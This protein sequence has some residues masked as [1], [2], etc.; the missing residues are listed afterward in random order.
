MKTIPSQTE[1][2][3]ETFEESHLSIKSRHTQEFNL[4]KIIAELRTYRDRV[5]S[6]WAII[7]VR[8]S[9]D[10]DPLPPLTKY[11]DLFTRRGRG[12]LNM[13]DFFYEMSH[14]KIDI[15]G[16][17][18][19]GWYT[20]DQRRADYVGNVYPQPVG[21]INR[22]GLLDAARAKAIAAGVNLADYSGVV[23]S[24]LNAVDLC[25]WVGGMA[26][27][28][29]SFSLSPSLMG[30]EM[31]HGYGLD[32]ARLNGSTEDYRD[33]WDV[34]STA[35]YPW[36]EADHSEFTKV[37]PGLN[38][39]SMR[40]LGWLDETRVWS[41]T[42]NAFDTTIQLRPLHSHELSGHLAAQIGE[43][44]IEFRIPERWDAA[45]PRPCILVHRFNSNHSYLMPAHSG[46]QDIVAGD[47]FQEGI[48]DLSIFG[49]KLVEVVQID[50]ASKTAIIR[51][52]QH[53][54]SIRDIEKEIAAKVLGGI[55]VDGE[56]FII[57]GGKIIRVPPR[58][59]ITE[60]V[61]QLSNYLELDNFTIGRANA[62]SIQKQILE[63]III[64]T[65]S[66]HQETLPFSEHPPGYNHK[67]SENH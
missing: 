2:Q 17:R 21:K 34:M 44:L 61:K 45:I 25:G 32:H 39:W 58:G 47:K 38:A 3:M 51:L 19:F 49:Y 67:S 12:D 4:A 5:I 48:P 14:H 63:S 40:S 27:L 26:A 56:G 20:L 18:V 42:S 50:V 22:N 24:G 15:S 10:T 29:D 31:G 13:V 57:I 30:Q 66:L 8:F 36:M 65:A 33:P 6:P 9:D 59:P 53:P 35:A 62:I 64:S 11:E 54:S 1:T 41:T 52:R 55:P 16:S 46:S 60:I 23:V 7:L 37:G 28:C 43:Y